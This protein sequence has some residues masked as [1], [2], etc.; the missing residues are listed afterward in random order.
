MLSRHLSLAKRLLAG[1]NFLPCRVCYTAIDRLS[2]ARSRRVFAAAGDIAY[3][4]TARACCDIYPLDNLF[5][6][7]VNAL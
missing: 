4:H 1:A 7:R 3:T 6:Q 5:D 2:G